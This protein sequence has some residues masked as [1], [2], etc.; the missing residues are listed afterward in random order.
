MKNSILKSISLFVICFGLTISINFSN[1]AQASEL[2][3]GGLE[4]DEVVCKCN[5]W[6]NCK[7]TGSREVCAS[8]ATEGDCRLYDVNCGN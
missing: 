2:D 8:F 6:G 4:G 7:V 1:T 3:P 5:W